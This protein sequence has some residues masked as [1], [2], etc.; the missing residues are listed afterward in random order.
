MQSAATDGVKSLAE[1]ID[2]SKYYEYVVLGQNVWNA[3]G[4][5]DIDEL[6]MPIALPEDFTNKSPVNIQIT[7]MKFAATHATMDLIGEFVLPDCDVLK[8]QILMF[9]APRLCISPDRILPES[10]TLALLSD[11]T[12]T[13]PDSDYDC[14][15]KAPKD[16]LNPVDGC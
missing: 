4:S 16:L 3:I 2:L 11:L 9:G 5:Q 14:T 13:D 8:D 1:K 12:L 6:Y 10:G 15:F 7:T